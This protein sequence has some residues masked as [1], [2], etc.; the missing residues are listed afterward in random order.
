MA[1]MIPTIR[2]N[3]VR[4]G[5]AEQGVDDAPVSYFE[6]KQHGTPMIEVTYQLTEDDLDDLI[7]NGGT[8][9]LYTVGT[10]IQPQ[11]LSIASIQEELMDEY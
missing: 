6:G 4:T 1:R 9:N 8:L 2:T 3:G 7:A 10:T 11:T 5:N